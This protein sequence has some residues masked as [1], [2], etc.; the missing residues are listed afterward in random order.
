MKN[1]EIVGKVVRTKDYIYIVDKNEDTLMSIA[2]INFG[3]EPEDGSEIKFTIDVEEEKE[4]TVPVT[5]STIKRKCGW[6][7]YC[8]VTGGN[9][10]M[11]NEHSVEDTE[12]FQVKVSHANELGL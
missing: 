2:Y 11:L 3:F 1:V 8:D 4:E 7:R 5:L 12:I 9:H 10:Y 6:N